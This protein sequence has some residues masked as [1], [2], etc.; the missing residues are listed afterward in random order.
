MNLIAAYAVLDYRLKGNMPNHIWVINVK[1][2]I[3]TIRVIDADENIPWCMRR[4]CYDNAA[5]ETL[6]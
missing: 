1:A 3:L 6:G 5:M 2:F 4:V